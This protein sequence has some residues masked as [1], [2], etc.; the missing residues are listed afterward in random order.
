MPFCI[1]KLVMSLQST[2]SQFKFALGLLHQVEVRSTFKLFQIFF[3]QNKRQVKNYLV[4]QQNHI[5]SPHIEKILDKMIEPRM[6][7][8]MQYYCSNIF[9]SF[10]VTKHIDEVGTHCTGRAGS[11]LIELPR[12]GS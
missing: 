8:T 6:H 10:S 2:F 9:K 4:S 7:I 11:S 1:I 12:L 3:I 5:F